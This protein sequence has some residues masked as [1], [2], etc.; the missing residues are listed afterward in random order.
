[1]NAKQMQRWQ[2]ELVGVQAFRTDLMRLLDSGVTL[3]IRT[4]DLREI[5]RRECLAREAE[6]TT[7]IN[8]QL[9]QT[10]EFTEEFCGI[11]AGEHLITPCDEY[12]VFVETDMDGV[13]ILGRE[14]LTSALS[15]GI[16]SSKV[17]GE[18]N[19]QLAGR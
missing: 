8:E 18:T 17:E 2:T 15:C 19:V 9:N 13:L 11:P 6:L 16:I 7:K 12:M 5:G 1:M 3:G 4:R 14:D 10:Y